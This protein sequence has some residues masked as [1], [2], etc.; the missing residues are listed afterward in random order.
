MREDLY[1]SDWLE[2]ETLQVVRLPV[3]AGSASTSAPLLN[4]IVHGAQAKL[5]GQR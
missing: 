1:G 5:R 3:G 2:A 4:L